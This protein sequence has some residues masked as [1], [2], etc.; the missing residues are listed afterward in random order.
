[1][2]IVRSRSCPDTAG[3]PPPPDDTTTPVDP[4]EDEFNKEVL[5]VFI[6]DEVYYP[7]VDMAPRRF[8][9]RA[10][11]LPKIR[12]VPGCEHDDLRTALSFAFQRL[13]TKEQVSS[14]TMKFIDHITDSERLRRR[15]VFGWL[16]A[17]AGGE[18]DDIHGPRALPHEPQKKSLQQRRRQGYIHSAVLH[19]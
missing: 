13:Y 16:L 4:D 17:A 2:S 1:M 14:T 8:G 12:L 3:V 15:R 5:D 6:N 7:F 11:S 10:E 18:S 19:C 9:G